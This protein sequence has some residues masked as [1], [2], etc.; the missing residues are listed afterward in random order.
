MTPFNLTQSNFFFFNYLAFQYLKRKLFTFEQD[1]A[2]SDLV[3]AVQRQPVVII[4]FYWWRGARYG[5]RPPSRSHL[6]SHSQVCDV[7]WLRLSASPTRA[8]RQRR[9][10][11][12][13]VYGLTSGVFGWRRERELFGIRLPASSST[14]VKGRNRMGGWEGGGCVFTT[15][16]GRH[17]F[18]LRVI[19]CPLALREQ[20]KVDKKPKQIAFNMN[21]NDISPF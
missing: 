3:R 5:Q 6:T 18:L 2:T 10:L 1:V 14:S 20:F 12:T 8:A 9:H 7:I 11:I 19:K 4:V 17:L 16:G 13:M 15:A 21:A